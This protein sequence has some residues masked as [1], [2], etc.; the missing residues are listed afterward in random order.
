MVS[1][2][3]SIIYSNPEYVY[4]IESR[5]EFYNLIERYSESD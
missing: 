2:D 3:D 4:Y 5:M 1:L